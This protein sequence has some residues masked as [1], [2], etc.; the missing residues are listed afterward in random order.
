MAG[1]KKADAEL[2][3][4]N[5][6]IDVLEKQ[7]S[8]SGEVLA[9]NSDAMPQTAVQSA[10]QL[11][12][13]AVQYIQDGDADGIR[14]KLWD[15]ALAGIQKVYQALA[16]AAYLDLE[17]TSASSEFQDCMTQA[18]TIIAEQADV[19][20]TASFSKQEAERLLKEV[21]GSKG[22]QQKQSALLKAFLS[23]ADQEEQGEMAKMAQV[24]AAKMEEEENP[25]VF[26]QY[27]EA[28]NEY[29]PLK[30]ISECLGF[31]YVFDN[32]QKRV[33][34]SKKGNIIL[35]MCLKKSMRTETRQASLR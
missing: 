22:S 30:A 16:G 1:A 18:E 34:L 14:E 23:A 8:Q 19:L 15:A 25:Y 35:F 13:E 9:G 5:L 12:K 29:I 11:T 28:V 6:R 31:R 4:L 24:L 3:E 2:E 33:T 20:Q 17:N 32:Y 26:R 10:Q 7:I 27:P 21:S